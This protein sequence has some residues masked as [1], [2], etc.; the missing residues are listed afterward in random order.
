MESLH[1]TKHALLLGG[2]HQPRFQ[3]ARDCTLNK[4]FQ[5]PLRELS[6]WGIE[7]F[8]NDEN[9]VSL[10]SQATGL[11]YF[12]MHYQSRHTP[13]LMSANGFTHTDLWEHELHEQLHRERQESHWVD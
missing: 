1:R 4:H 8:Q 10:Y 9:L 11:T 12:L 6:G 3:D 5:I 13:S 2:S 7:S